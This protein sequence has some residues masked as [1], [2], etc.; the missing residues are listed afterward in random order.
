MAHRQTIKDIMIDLSPSG[1][2]TDAIIPV[3]FAVSTSLSDCDFGNTE[4]RG[5]K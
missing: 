5:L 1:A 4:S 3:L 2:G